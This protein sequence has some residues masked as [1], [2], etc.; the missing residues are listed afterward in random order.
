MKFQNEYMDIKTINV[1]LDKW[2][3]KEYT[4]MWKNK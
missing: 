4:T 3:A 1:L 2:N